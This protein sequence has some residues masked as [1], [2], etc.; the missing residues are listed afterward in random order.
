MER[1][2]ALLNS[3]PTERLPF[4]TWEKAH[5]VYTRRIQRMGIVFIC[6]VVVLG[7]LLAVIVLL[8]SQP[9][10]ALVCLI[11][12]III[13]YSFFRTSLLKES[14]SLLRNKIAFILVV[15]ACLVVVV[16][17]PI[18][19]WLITI[20]NWITN[21]SILAVP[22]FIAVY[23]F[24]SVLGIPNIVMILAAGTLFGLLEGVITVSI[25]D[26]LSI[27]VCYVIGKTFVRRRL[28]S[29]L[30][31]NSRLHKLDRAFAK[32]GW[33]IVLL[34]RLSPVLPSSI[35]NY[36]FSITQINFWK[37]LFFS[38]LGML[39]VIFTYVY[40]GAFSTTI[41]SSNNKPET[42][43][44]QVIGLAATCGVM[45]YVTKLSISALKVKTTENSSSP[46]LPNNPEQWFRQR[47]P[48][49]NVK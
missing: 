3:I 49:E 45:I 6:S 19:T 46:S 48:S 28:T 32:K 8:L 11:G 7:I 18:S 17:L 13:L 27:A 39:P 40:I 41:L 22:V 25:A 16:N 24:A 12:I 9:G 47:Y 38:W 4:N 44:F 34:T 15:A 42:F 36:G 10:I 2:K 23:V 37:Y 1:V 5:R 20:Q 30:R 14:Q 35:L 31:E 26:T 21:Q 33:K 29:S 43:I